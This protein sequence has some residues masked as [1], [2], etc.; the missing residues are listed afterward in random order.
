MITSVTN[1]MFLRDG[2]GTGAPA[3]VPA[4][5]LLHGFSDS[6]LA[7][8]NLFKTGLA[9]RYRLLAPDLPGFGVSRS[10]GYGFTI[11]DQVTALL[12]LINSKTPDGPIGFVGHSVGSILAV[13]AAKKMTARCAGIFSIEGNLTEADAYFSGQA[14]D[15]EDADT[16]KRE[17]ASKIWAKGDGD[18]IFRHYHASI[19]FAEA[20]AM[21]GFGRD[22][23]RYSAGDR[24]GHAF[25]E[26]DAPALYYWC[27]ANTPA[28]SVDFIANNGLS[29]ETFHDASHW[30]ML[31][32]P[33]TVAE[34]INAFFQHHLDL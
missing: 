32:I 8:R 3:Q 27:A 29:N 28:S 7:F 26:V 23:R 21:W 12:N 14:A 16:F 24:P 19:M 15:Y 11:D 1:G 34:R 9:D 4:L 25:G 20:N 6:G 22:V 13:E 2:G 33:K 10:E 30:P 5:W 31:D 17:F 18:P